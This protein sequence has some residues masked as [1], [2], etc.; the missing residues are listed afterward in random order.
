MKLTTCQL[1]DSY[2]PIMDGVGMVTRNYF[3]KEDDGSSCTASGA[4]GQTEPAVVLFDNDRDCSDYLLNFPE[5]S[6]F[7]AC[8]AFR[9]YGL[10]REHG[11]H[12]HI[13]PM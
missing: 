3:T 4:I 10:S 13:V 7:C 9:K 6:A 2:S 11:P 5:S 8:S 1:N 12:R